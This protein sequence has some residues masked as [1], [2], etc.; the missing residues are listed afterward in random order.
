MSRGPLVPVEGAI[1]RLPGIEMYGGSIPAGTVG[2]DVFE[3]LNFQQRYDID[4][5]I[6]RALRLS[7]E[8]LQPL[9]AGATPQNYT[10]V[11][12]RWMLSKR[13]FTAVTPPSSRTAFATPD[14]KWLRIGQPGVV[15]E[16]ITSITPLSLTSTERTISSS[17]MSR[18]SSGS[19]TERSASITWSSVGMT[20]FWQTSS[21]ALGAS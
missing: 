16:T 10:D 18:R 7:E 21:D 19:I 4:A 8:Y 5:R 12:V 17:T 3:Y 11:H 6:A 2:G 15:S 20:P 13:T 14:W 1:P 9:P